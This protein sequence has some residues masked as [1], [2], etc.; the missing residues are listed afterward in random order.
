MA[1]F[2]HVL[3][4]STIKTNVSIM[5][6]QKFKSSSLLALAL[7]V[8]FCISIII[9][10]VIRSDLDFFKHTLSYYALGDKG[11]VQTTGFYSIGLSQILI[12]FVLVKNVAVT[13]AKYAAVFLALAGVGALLVATFPKQPDTADIILRLPHIAG[14]IMQFLFFPTALLSLVKAIKKSNYRSYTL[15]TGLFTAVMFFVVLT[16]F[17]LKHKINIPVFGLIEKIDILA[18]TCWLIFISY[19]MTRTS[20]LQSLFNAK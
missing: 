3:I 17:I 1:A 11:L 9:A 16:L 15:Y 7:S 18:V 10:H 4:D 8:Y 20:L 19:V 13:R 5:G 2:S 6:N 12:S 14:A